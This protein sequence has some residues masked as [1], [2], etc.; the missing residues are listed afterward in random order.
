MEYFCRR[1][2]SIPYSSLY[3]IFLAQFGLCYYSI[4]L[5]PSS[6]RF[7]IEFTYNFNGP[8]NRIE[9]CEVGNSLNCHRCFAYIF[10]VGNLASFSNSLSP[11]YANTSSLK[12]RLIYFK[13][14][15]SALKFQIQKITKT[16]T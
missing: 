3:C 10:K 4:Q 2:S 15:I 11:P 7:L 12:V 8:W 16:E 1:P 6:L 5:Y 9:V 14:L 13:L